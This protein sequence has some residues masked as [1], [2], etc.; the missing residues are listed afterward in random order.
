MQSFLRFR[1][2][3][4]ASMIAAMAYGL[5]CIAPQPSAAQGTYPNHPVR[6]IVPLGVGSASDVGTRVLTDALSQVTGQ[7]FFVENRPGAAGNLGMAAGAKATPDGYTLVSGGF[8]I[9]VLSQFMYTP[10]QM[11]FDPVKDL[12]PI[13]LMGRTPMMIAASP[14]F[15]PN[16]IQEL[17]A[18]AR[19]KPGTINVAMANTA[20]RLVF[21]LFSKS[22]GTS[23]FPILY[24]TTGAAVTD[25]ISGIVSVNVDTL[26]ALRP[27]LL[28]SGGRLKPIAVTTRKST[29]LL[30]NVTSVAEQGVADFELVGYIS[31]YGPKGMPREAINYL[32]AELNKILLL[33]ETKKRFDALGLEPGGGTPKDLA[34][35]E[36]AQRALW[37]PLIKKANITPQ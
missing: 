29:D 1:L 33:P 2:Y 37:G 3:S 23:L 21:E 19:A 20:S 35:F 32:N 27:Q 17:I 22:T 5:V 10:E 11:G 34:D 24:K 25:T 28:S 14:S 18:A 36:A 12:E 8:G 15:A 30:P 6:V 4:R 16:N 13:I 26:S 7:S 31:L 9:T